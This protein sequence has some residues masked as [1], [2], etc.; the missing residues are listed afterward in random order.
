MSNKKQ[1]EIFLLRFFFVQKVTYCTAEAQ[2]DTE[3]L[4]WDKSHLIYE[5]QNLFE[6]KPI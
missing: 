4:P 6:P 1:T 5:V 3:S 2:I